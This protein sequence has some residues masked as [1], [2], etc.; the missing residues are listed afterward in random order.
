METSALKKDFF[1][2]L[3]TVYN[4][5][6]QSE[7]KVGQ[8]LLEHS[9][10]AVELSLADVASSAGVSDATAMRFSRSVGYSGWLE[11]KIALIRSL[12]EQPVIDSKAEGPFH[13]VMRKSKQAL[14]ETALAFDQD[15]FN[16]LLDAILIS[17]KILVAGSGTSAPIAYDL[18][19]RLF[20]LGLH[21][22][23]ESDVMLQMMQASLMDEKD[24]LILISQ[25]AAS[26]MVM[27]A[28]EVAKIHGTP[29]ATITGS[30]LTEL[31]RASE[32][33]LLSVSHEPNPETVASRI[34]QH[35]L[36]QAIYV[37]LSERMGE[38]ARVCEDR[39]W[40]S[41]FMDS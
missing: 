29:I 37:G 30:S 14:D 21:V 35:V 36:V 9:Y 24:L 32:Y 10:E 2:R 22:S 39:I 13:A 8:F 28:V 27:K 15:V 38:D 12:P 7:K 17:R 31:A 23:V 41:F 33:L 34:A 26:E 11:L 6:S 1:A 5:L 25:S 16:R 4:S 18:Y 19:N 20:R 3:K 40:D